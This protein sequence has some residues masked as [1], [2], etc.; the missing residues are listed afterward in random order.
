MSD[1]LFTYIEQAKGN[2]VIQNALAKAN[3]IIAKF[4]RPACSISGGGDSDIMLDILSKVDTEHKVI[5]VWFDTGIEYQATKNHLNYLEEKYG[6]HIQREKAIKS[7]PF[8]CREYGQPFLSKHVSEQIDRLQ[9]HGFQWEDEPYE[10]LKNKYDNCD[11]ALKWWTNSYETTTRGYSQFNVNYN[12]LLK[13][14]LLSNPPRFK[15]SKKCCEYAKKAVAHNFAK[16]NQLDLFVVGVRKSEG[17]TRSTSYSNCFSDHSSDNKLSQ[18]RPLFWFKDDDKIA[19]ENIFD[20]KHSDCYEVYGLKRTGC[21]GCPYGR[22]LNEELSVVEEYEPK[23]LKA[24]NN[25]FKDSY[26]YTKQYHKFV[27]EHKKSS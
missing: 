2:E 1:K 12:S 27:E 25:I 10:V 17:G 20:I 11:S 8:S 4:D 7:I 13:E 9:R 16:K 6:I 21:V 14:F 18:Y 19:Y 24:I 3:S 5:Y 22:R 15:V 26:E 23:L